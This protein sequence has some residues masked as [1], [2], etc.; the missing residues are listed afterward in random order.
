MGRA[1]V[2]VTGELLRELLHFPVGTHVY[3]V[4]VIVEHPDIHE[5]VGDCSD[6]D[7]IQKASPK[8]ERQDPVVFKGWN[9]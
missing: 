6:I 4:D 1:R 2:W 9:V 5:K 7:D 3:P 8:F